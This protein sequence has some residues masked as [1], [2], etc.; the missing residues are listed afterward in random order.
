MREI[1]P[2]GSEGGGGS[3]PLPTS[4]IRLSGARSLRLQRIRSFCPESQK[5]AQSGAD[6]RQQKPEAECDAEHQ[7]VAGKGREQLAQQGKLGENRRKSDARHGG[8]D[9]ALRVAAVALNRGSPDW[10]QSGPP[11]L[12]THRYSDSLN[13]ST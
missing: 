13:A 2:S 6:P 12:A 9:K 1:R 7:F 3:I 5:P 8:E 11:P 4:I 10:G